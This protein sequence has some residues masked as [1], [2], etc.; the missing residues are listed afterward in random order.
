MDAFHKAIDDCHLR[1]LRFSGGIFTWKRGRSPHNMVQERLDR[2][3]ANDGWWSK[4][5]LLDSKH[6]RCL[7][8]NARRWLRRPGNMRVVYCSYKD[9]LVRGQ[10]EGMGN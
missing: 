9:N 8:K 2:F 1:D 10:I 5:R 6:F 3:L 7:A 4:G